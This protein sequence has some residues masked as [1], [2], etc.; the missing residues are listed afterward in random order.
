MSTVEQF[1]DSTTRDNNFFSRASIDNRYGGTIQVSLS[2][3]PSTSIL[4]VLRNYVC[5][6]A[7]FN[8]DDRDGAPKCHPE[9][10]RSIIDD[11]KHWATGVGADTGV[12]WLKGPVGTGKSAIA[13]K[14]CEDLDKQNPRLLAG[15]FFFWRNDRIRNS[16]RTFVS[17]IVQRLIVFSEVGEQI[18]R[19]LANDP[20]TLDHTPE[21]QWETLVIKPLCQGLLNTEFTQRSL[22]VI[23]GLDECEPRSDQQQVLRLLSSLQ[24][25]GLH[26]R[27]AVLVASRPESHIRSEIDT[28]MHGHPSLFR[29]PHPMLS[30]TEES[31]NHMHLILTTSFNSIHHRRRQIIGN[32]QWPPEGVVDR[33]IDVAN[34]QFIYVLTI[35]RWLSDEDGHPVERLESIYQP[36]DR[37]HSR[38]FAPLDRL[39]TL[40]LET[41]CKKQAGDLVLHCLFLLTY[42]FHSRMHGSSKESL[43]QASKLS[44]VLQKNCGY[45]RLILQP[46]HSVLRIP[47]GDDDTIHIY[48][49]SFSEY[50]HDRS[51]SGVYWVRHPDV[52]TLLLT[53]ILELDRKSIGFANEEQ[54]LGKVWLYL[55]WVDIIEVTPDLADSLARTHVVEWMQELEGVHWRGGVHST[56]Y[57]EF[58][59]WLKSLPLP[60]SHKVQ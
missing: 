2:G 37:H 30:E 1:S 31:R 52:L 22:I 12:L 29:L 3:P 18:Y 39:Y 9:T 4:E 24:E 45:I 50:L 14:V 5:L 40:I 8:G 49:K 35:V 59:Q 33:I 56:P 28:L 51:R 13:R 46:L 43:H 20:S 32:C 23:D 34:G 57:G 26:R 36:Y 53:K 60:R 54:G 15:S 19:A 7:V 16:L 25:N 27:I 17:T 38:A 41:A 11:I 10:R 48:H 47:D 44:A 58:C 42:G 55:P 21:V 6:R